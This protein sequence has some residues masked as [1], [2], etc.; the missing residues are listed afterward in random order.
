VLKQYPEKEEEK[1][2]PSS[3]AYSLAM[4]QPLDQS[5]PLLDPEMQVPSHSNLS[6]YR[7]PCRPVSIAASATS[8]S[9]LL[10][11]EKPSAGIII[12]LFQ[13]LVNNNMNYRLPDPIYH[14]KH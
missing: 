6:L 8:S 14:P 10:G 11:N 1:K 2:K 5:R 13:L 4:P 12:L 7:V 9:S 3:A